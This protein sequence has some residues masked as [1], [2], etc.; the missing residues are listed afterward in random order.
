MLKEKCRKDNVLCNLQS[1]EMLWLKVKNL[2]L[3]Q[4]IY[5][6]LNV[7]F[8]KSTHEESSSFILGG[9]T[10]FFHETS[11]L[12]NVQWYVKKQNYLQQP[13]ARHLFHL[14]Q[15]LLLL[16]DR[17]C[18]QSDF[19]R[20]KGLGALWSGAALNPEG[21]AWQSSTVNRPGKDE[22]QISRGTSAVKDAGF[23]A[24]ASSLQSG[25]S[26]GSSVWTR[27]GWA[28]FLAVCH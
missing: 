26:S 11:P 14:L 3:Q 27:K 9:E 1:L 15:L 5:H 23:V 16:A 10:G 2:L 28:L 22:P 25:L 19:F 8:P 21:I 18:I 24:G 6:F 12:F 4:A 20:T 13:A 7:F 17:L